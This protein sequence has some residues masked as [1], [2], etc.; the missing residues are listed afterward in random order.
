MG[1][2]RIRTTMAA[3]AVAAA[4]AL[5]GCGGGGSGTGQMVTAGDSGGTEFDRLAAA[6]E[7]AKVPLCQPEEHEGFIPLPAPAAPA[8]REFS[9]FRYVEGRIYEFGPCQLPPGAR[10]ELRAYRYDDTATRDQALTDVSRRNTRPTSTFAFEDLY[11][12]EIWSPEPSMDSPAGQAAA[13]VHSA[14][15]RVPQARHH[16]V[17]TA[18]SVSCPPA[19]PA[20]PAGPGAD[21]A[22]AVS[23]P[24]FLFCP[25]DLTVAAGTEVRW[26]NSDAAPHTATATGAEAAFDSGTL[27]TGQSFAFRFDRPGA[28][29]Y[30]CRLHPNM[31]GTITVT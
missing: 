7:G 28:Y 9:Y 1:D 6:V 20:T 17:P 14:M 18:A 4:V 27:A 8:A 23:I 13:Q 24:A 29:E 10:N 3:A 5:A 2:N 21:G 22:T 31:R 19:G 30:F 11:A 26:T 15:S 16:D 25:A 12:V